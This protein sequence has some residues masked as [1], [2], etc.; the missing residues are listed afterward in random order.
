MVAAYLVLSSPLAKRIPNP[1]HH[2]HALRETMQAL[3]FFAGQVLLNNCD[4]VLVKHFFPAEQ[5]GL[6]AA[7]ALVGRVI[8]SFS[9]AVVNSTFSIVAG[10]RDE[11]RRDLRVIATSLLLVLGSGTVI[12]VGLCFAPAFIWT[13]LFGAGFVLTGRHS[14]SYLLA[15]YALAA[16]VY[17]LSAVIITF[18]MSYKIANTS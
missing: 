16:V 2:S 8:Y 13:K 14:L 1:L 11:E 18:E 6:Y 5:A 17:S 10:T 7:I 15:L 4:V 9:Q 12:A 3:I